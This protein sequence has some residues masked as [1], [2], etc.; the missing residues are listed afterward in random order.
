VYDLVHAVNTMRKE[1]GLELTDRIR[2]TIPETDRDLLEHGDWI[3][4]ETLAVAV[5]A[6]GGEIR[7]ERV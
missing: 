7:L 4:R 2:L 1:E 3:A 6:D 5:D